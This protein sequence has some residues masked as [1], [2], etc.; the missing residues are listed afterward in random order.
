MVS[1]IEAGLAVVDKALSMGLIKMKERYK[2]EYFDLRLKLKEERNKI[3]DQRDYGLILEMEEELKLLL[4]VFY[5]E[6][7]KGREE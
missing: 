6:I 3:A 4:D 7:N 5:H 1:L 2:R